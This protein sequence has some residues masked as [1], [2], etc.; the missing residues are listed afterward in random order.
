MEQNSSTNRNTS[1]N[2]ENL[3]PNQDAMSDAEVT[4]NPETVPIGEE[5]LSDQNIINPETVSAEQDFIPNQDISSP[6]TVVS[7]EETTSSEQ[8]SRNLIIPGILLGAVIGGVIALRDS[9]TREKVVD[10]AVTLKDTSVDMF[11]QLKENPKETINEIMDQFKTASSSLQEAMNEALDIYQL[12][13]DQL[14]AIKNGGSLTEN[15]SNAANMVNVVKEAK[16]KA[17]DAVSK[18]A[19]AG[20][21]FSVPSSDST[22]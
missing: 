21:S 18:V 5:A 22:K 17:K 20:D 12:V 6:E 10:G 8:S 1:S 19:E 2:P 13:N 3:F 14:S 7:Y 16:E 4:V 15:L 9:T 11:S